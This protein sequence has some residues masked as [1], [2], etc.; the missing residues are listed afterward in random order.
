MD[1]RYYKQGMLPTTAPHETP[2]M[3]PIWDGSIWKTKGE[4]TPLLARWTTEYD[5]GHE[6]EWWYC[7]KDSPLVLSEQK[8]K[9]RYE[10]NRANKMFEVLEINPMEYTE[11]IFRIQTAAWATYPE[12][13]RPQSDPEAVRRNVEKWSLQYKIFAAFCVEDGE[14]AGYALLNEHDTWVD[15]SV[16]KADPQYEKKGVNVAVI[17]KICEYYNERLKKGY[18]ICDGERNIIHETAF[19][20]FLIK[21]FGFRRAYC[22]LNIIY[23]KPIGLM[24]KILYPFRDVISKMKGHSM[25]KKINAILLMECI[26]RKQR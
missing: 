16:L 18:Y 3:T 24:V 11:E 12:S 26:S 4:Q 15:F 10:I 17:F 8:S 19:Q 6:T 21:K 14:M 5:C 23:R 1:W 9:V 22:K 13:Y 2:D 20:D 25:I 7:I